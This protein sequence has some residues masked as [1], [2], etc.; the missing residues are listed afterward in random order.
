MHLLTATLVVL[1]LYDHNL[2]IDSIIGRPDT[3]F[4]T[5]DILDLNYIIQNNYTHI[6]H[7]IYHV[8]NL[9]HI[10]FRLPT[11]ILKHCHDKFA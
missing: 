7:I 2:P 8:T 3:I 6:K 10:F 1:G 4:K 11:F 5:N 9:C